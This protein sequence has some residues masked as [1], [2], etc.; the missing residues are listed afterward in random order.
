M[1]KKRT[2]KNRQ[3]FVAIPFN[4]SIAL[5]T[6]ANNTVLSTALF[7]SAFGED[8]FIISIDSTWHIDALTDGQGPIDVGFAHSDLTVDEVSEA[9]SAE[10]TD[11]DDII[12]KERAR[13]PV[14]RSGIFHGKVGGNESLN[15][16]KP[17]RTKMKF[18]V[19]D[20]HQINFWQQNLSGATLTTG[21]TVRVSGTIFGRWQR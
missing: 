16:G 10:L 3:G 2:G 5:S 21:A 15:D 11:P 19:G 13:R 18:S 9:L 4:S 7:G 12:Q 17:I 20:G 8:I 6:L 1:R 14:R